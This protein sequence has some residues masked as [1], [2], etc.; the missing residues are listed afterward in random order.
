MGLVKHAEV[1]QAGQFPVSKGDKGK[2]ELIKV[3]K[4]H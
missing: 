2:S 4:K 1:M 3:F